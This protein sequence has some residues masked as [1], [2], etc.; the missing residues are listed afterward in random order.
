M[1]AGITFTVYSEAGNIDRAWPFDVVPRIIDKSEWDRIEAGL[2]QRLKA[3]NCFIDDIYHDK[4]IVKDGVFPAEVL[5]DSKNFRAA[6]VG[7][8]PPFGVGLTRPTSCAT[9]TAVYA[10]RQR[11]P[12]LLHAGNRR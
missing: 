3:L 5:A 1:A 9:A 7:A 10:G 2:K 8:N 6:C 11:V 4:R 12:S